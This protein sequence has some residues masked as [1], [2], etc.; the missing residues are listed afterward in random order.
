MND[1]HNKIEILGDDFVVEVYKITKKF[2]VDERFA[3]TQQL[4][5]VATSIM[6][7]YA[8]GRAKRSDGHYGS[9]INSSYGSLKEVL[10]GYKK[11]FKE[12]KIRK[13]S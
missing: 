4:R 5:R 1:F 7:N 9:H 10:Y 11:R 2:P 12:K 8:E 6:L 3:L 13:K